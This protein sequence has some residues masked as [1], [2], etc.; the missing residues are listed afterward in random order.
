MSAIA[1]VSAMA[2]TLS[3]KVDQ[4]SCEDVEPVLWT[5]GLLFC[6]LRMFNF[7]SGICAV[8]SVNGYDW[9]FCY[10]AG[11]AA[12]LSSCCCCE[13]VS[14]V[15]LFNASNALFCSINVFFYSI[16]LGVPYLPLLDV[17][18]DC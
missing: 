11:Y 9:L 6:C 13:W 7:N 12:E 18:S 10:G 17:V 3:R 14:C 2:K 8:Y 5:C 16:A 4:V 15:C 1:T